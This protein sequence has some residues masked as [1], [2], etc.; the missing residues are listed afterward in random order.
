MK[1]FRPGMVP[2]QILKNMYGKGVLLEEINKIVSE[3]INNYIKDN[4]I[5]IIG[6]PKPESSDI[7]NINVNN[8]DSIEFNFKV[9]HLSDFKIKPFK[10]S[11]KFKLY[12]IKVEKKVLNETITNL[13][14]QYAD[15]NNLKVVTEKSSVYGDIEVNGENK[16]GLLNFENLDKKKV[17]KL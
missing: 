6:E 17:K 15:V 11:Q 2:I 7:E 8:L 16:K 9:G 3:K 4:K 14:N 13:R 1:G 10:K 5:K 12:N